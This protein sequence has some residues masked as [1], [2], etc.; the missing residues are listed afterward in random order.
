MNDLQTDGFHMF[1]R[2]EPLPLDHVINA[3]HVFAKLHAV[4]LVIKDQCPEKF[5][6]FKSIEDIFE[7]RK[8]DIQLN[9]YFESL[10]VTTLNCIDKEKEFYYWNKLNVYFNIGT[11]Y[12]LL[13]DLLNSKSSEPY[14]VICHGDCWINNI[15]FKQEVII[16]YLKNYMF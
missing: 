8:Y 4:S 7:Q 14:S 9:N 11:L 15:M 12:E 1:N 3:M 10:K 16:I 5:V 2:L 13:L 6:V